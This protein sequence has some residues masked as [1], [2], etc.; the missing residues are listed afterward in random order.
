MFPCFPGGLCYN[1]AAQN[2]TQCRKQTEEEQENAERKCR[3]FFSL[4]YPG[5][6]KKCV[7]FFVFH[8][9][10]HPSWTACRGAATNESTTA[11]FFF[12]S[13]FLD[14]SFLFIFP[15]FLPNPKWT[16]RSMRECYGRRYCIHLVDKENKNRYSRRRTVRC[17]CC[18]FFV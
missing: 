9:S 11:F 5:K 2:T 6:K 14:C 10:P 18:F 3:F 4:E 1:T 8:C 16:S 12:F 7:A 17:C 13:F 15:F